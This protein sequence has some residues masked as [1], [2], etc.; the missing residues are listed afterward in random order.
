[1]NWKKKIHDWFKDVNLGNVFIQCCCYLL[2][3]MIPFLCFLSRP[4]YRREKEELVYGTECPPL[5]PK[6]EELALVCDGLYYDTKTKIAWFWDGESPRDEAV[7][8]YA[9]N[10]FPYWYDD[11][12]GMLM[13]FD[14]KTIIKE[15]I[16][17]YEAEKMVVE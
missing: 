5:I 13:E 10:G 11:F 7:P 1:M 3:V 8:Y 4:E 9:S 15:A 2:V 14:V 16:A 6:V 17:E 12:T